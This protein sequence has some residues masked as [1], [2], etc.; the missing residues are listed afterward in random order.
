MLFCRYRKMPISQRKRQT[1]AII[2]QTSRNGRSLRRF[3]KP[4]RQEFH[5]NENPRTRTS[6]RF[7]HQNQKVARFNAAIGVD[8]RGDRID[9]IR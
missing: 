1:A 6:K 7:N 2:P 8:E 3:L 4:K 9:A 5:A